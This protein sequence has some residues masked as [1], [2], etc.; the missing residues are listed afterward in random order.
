LCGTG[1]SLD[2]NELMLSHDVKRLQAPTN[3][4]D[5]GL[6]IK[7]ALRLVGNVS[8]DLGYGWLTIRNYVDLNGNNLWITGC[9]ETHLIGPIIGTGNVAVG[10]DDGHSL[11]FE[12]T[13][14]NTFTV[15]LGIEKKFV[16]DDPGEIIFDKETGVVVNGGLRVGEGAICKLARSHQIGDGAT[17]CISDGG[18][19][20]LQGH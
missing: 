20:L 6:L 3:Y 10:V 13:A 14:G 11:R 8:I 18:Q 17:V 16:E 9:Y 4:C 7:C 15:I 19:F 1:W 2:G 12:G 5:P